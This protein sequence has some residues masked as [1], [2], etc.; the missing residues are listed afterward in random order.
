MSAAIAG[1]QRSHAHGEGIYTGCSGVFSAPVNTDSDSDNLFLVLNAS[2]TDKGAP[3]VAPLI[4]TASYVFPPRHKQA[5]FC[6]TNSNVTTALTAD[7][8]GGG[9]DVTSINHGSFI[10]LWP[11]NLTN[12]TGITF[13]VASSGVGGRIETHVDSPTGPLLGTA[14]VPPT[15]GSYTNI[16]VAMSDPGGTHTLYFVFLRNLGDK[17]LFVVNWLEFQGPGL[18]LSP[19]PFGGIARALPGIVQ[20][21]DFDEG[22]E[23]VAYHDTDASNTGGQYRSTGVDIENTADTG[24]GFDINSTVAGEYRLNYTVNASA[25]GSLHHLDTRGFARQRW[26]L[27]HRVQWRQQNWTDGHPQHR[28]FAGLANV[29]R[30]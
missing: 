9:L 4:G 17:N 19:A 6:T 13:R 27:P 24:G 26:H 23:G 21:E 22:G 15:G 16:S 30:Q 5:E 28:R 7:P 8:A 12:I 11:V 25:A 20:A 2:Y 18:A 10:G 14:N 29:E 3:G 1:P